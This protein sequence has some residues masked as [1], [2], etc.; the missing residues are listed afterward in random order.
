M[1]GRR[2][3]SS[4]ASVAD[5][6]MPSG[7]SDLAVR[8]WEYVLSDPEAKA[9]L[10]GEA[11]DWG[12]N[13]NPWYSTNPEVNPTGSGLALPAESFPKADPVEKPDTTEATGNGT[14]PINL[15]TWRP[16]HQQLR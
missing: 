10:D 11:D 16:V 15:V 5:M 8:L 7:R 12:M 3:S 1:S 6:L 4:A 13:V 14:G 9:W 2:R